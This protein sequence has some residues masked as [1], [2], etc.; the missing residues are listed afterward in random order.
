MVEG[1]EPVRDLKLES[2]FIIKGVES[3]KDSRVELG[4]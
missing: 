3:V 4:W 1:V 2:V